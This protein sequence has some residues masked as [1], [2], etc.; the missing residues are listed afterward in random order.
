MIAR[1]PPRAARIR[2]SDRR[3]IRLLDALALIG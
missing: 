3:A 2:I 1:A